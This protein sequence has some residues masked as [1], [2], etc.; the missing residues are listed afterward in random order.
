M[1]G[2]GFGEM[3]RLALELEDSPGAGTFTEVWFQQGNQ[4]NQWNQITVDLSSED[5]TGQRQ[6]RFVATEIVTGIRSDMAVD[7]IRI[8]RNSV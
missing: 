6:I 5:N 4:G 2:T 8:Q 7:E 1:W 3:G